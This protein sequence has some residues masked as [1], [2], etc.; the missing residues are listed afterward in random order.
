MG[1]PAWVAKTP[2]ASPLLRSASRRRG[3]GEVVHHIRFNSRS[4]RGANHQ[5][6]PSCKNPELTKVAS[7]KCDQATYLGSNPCALMV[8]ASSAA[9]SRP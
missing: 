9:H 5:F 7:A 1:F 6:A 8:P 2:I 3:G 4:G